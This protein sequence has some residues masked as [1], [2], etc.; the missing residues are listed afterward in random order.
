MRDPRVS[1]KEV[2]KAFASWDS[3]LWPKGRK[4]RARQHSVDVVKFVDD[5]RRSHRKQSWP[6]IW[7]A[8]EKKHRGLYANLKSFQNTYYELRKR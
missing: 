5:Y 4:P 1:A 7:P 2:A 3:F 6:D 8:F